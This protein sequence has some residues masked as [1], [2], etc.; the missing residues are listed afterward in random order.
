MEP[1]I[2]HIEITVRDMAIAV[3]FYDKFLPL[4]GFDLKSRSHAHIAQRGADVLLGQPRAARN[5]P[6][7]GR[8]TIG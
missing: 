8:Q 2:D 5:R 7:R 4:L 1:L 6:Q 3:P